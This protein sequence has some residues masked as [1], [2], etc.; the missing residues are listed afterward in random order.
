MNLIEVLEAAAASAECCQ[1]AA[2]DYDSDSYYA[3]VI[4][5]TRRHLSELETPEGLPPGWEYNEFSNRG[6]AGA[7]L[8]GACSVERASRHEQGVDA[9]KEV[10]RLAWAVHRALGGES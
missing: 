3:L 1:R 2:V 7:Y 9:V 8:P 4:S 6:W 10:S 5:E